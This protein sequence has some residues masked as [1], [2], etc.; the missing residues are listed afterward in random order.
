ML[1]TKQLA[2]NVYLTYCSTTNTM[3]KHCRKTAPQHVSITNVHAVKHNVS[4]QVLQQYK[5]LPSLYNLF[6][7]CASTKQTAQ[8]LINTIK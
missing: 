1:T 5:A 4:A 2:R 6:S 8:Q 7:K 3:F